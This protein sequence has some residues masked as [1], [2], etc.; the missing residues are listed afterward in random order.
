[1]LSRPSSQ[2]SLPKKVRFGVLA[3]SI[4]LSS[5][6]VI[7]A[8]VSNVYP[9]GI[10]IYSEPT[11]GRYIGLRVE[12]AVFYWID[13]R[14]IPKPLAFPY[15]IISTNRFIGVFKNYAPFDGLTLVVNKCGKP[16]R[17]TRSDA[18][19]GA[20]GS[21]GLRS[22]SLGGH[23]LAR[24]WVNCYA[25]ATICGLVSV[26][27]LMN[28]FSSWSRRRYRIRRGL[29]IRCGYDLFGSDSGTCSECGHPSP[30]RQEP[31]PRPR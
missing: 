16:F 20:A 24:Y 7:L 15:D 12:D 11:T 8:I 18:I 14:M 5:L 1:M 9:L 31:P 23:R 22:I 30:A 10:T 17:L 13:A 3:F 6:A 25:F 21:T 26:V 29:C 19:A 4:S 2:M 27:L 28:P